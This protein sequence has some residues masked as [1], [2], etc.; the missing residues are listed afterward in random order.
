[1]MILSENCAPSQ[2][3]D[4]GLLDSL[5]WPNSSECFFRE[6]WEKKH[7]YISSEDNPGLSEIFA[8]LVTVDDI[9]ELL[10]KTYAAGPRRENAVRM[11]KGGQM[12]APDEILVSRESSLAEIDVDRVLSFYREGASIILNRVDEA[13]D[14]VA[15]LCNEL[16]AL[17]GIPV[18]ANAYVTP[19]KAQGFPVHFDTHDVFLLQVV[20][21]KNWRLYG[22]PVSL[23]TPPMKNVEFCPPERPHFNICLDA[24]ELLY[25]PRGMLHEGVTA[26]DMSIHLTIGI[27]A[28]TW[29]T[30][31]Q[32]AIATLEK[33]HVLLRRSVVP[34]LSSVESQ[35]EQLKSTFAELAKIIFNLDSVQRTCDQRVAETRRLDRRNHRGRFA[36]MTQSSK[37]LP[38]D[39]V[40][41]KAGLQILLSN[42]SVHL[43]LNDKTLIMPDF[44]EPHLRLLCSRVPQSA[45][46][47]PS[48][49]D[50]TSKLVLLR[51]LLDE[52]MAELAGDHNM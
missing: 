14:P 9:D 39:K 49:L 10:S 6:T 31:L 24:G 34:R 40:R 4:H 16:S 52:G 36:Q 17:F 42:G 23:A 48:G 35:A 18:H 26:D 51:R 15:R 2:I 37:L 12:L 13:L 19:P 43:S 21:Q 29:S 28:F 25:I 11:G 47:M 30:M 41:C 3:G 27:H 5:I 22:S 50:E 20:G 32:R 8:H 7:L 46:E 44:V 38:N 45:T 1:M 33:D